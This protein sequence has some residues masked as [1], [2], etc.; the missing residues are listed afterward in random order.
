[1]SS[2]TLPAE[3]LARHSAEGLPVTR[4]MTVLRAAAPFLRALILAGIVTA[5]IMIGLPRVLAIAAAA[6]L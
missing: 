3:Q 2:G 1:M 4:T 5:L 6:S